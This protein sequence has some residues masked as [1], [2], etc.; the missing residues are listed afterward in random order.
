MVDLVTQDNQTGG[1]T[2]PISANADGQQ[3]SNDLSS[4]VQGAIG[5]DSPF[6]FDEEGMI[7]V[8]N[9]DGTVYTKI[10]PKKLPD[11]IR[12]K[13]SF[14][15]EQKKQAEM[16]KDL[17]LKQQSMQQQ[18]PAYN[19][20]PVKQDADYAVEG[21]A[22]AKR[23]NLNVDPNDVD[24]LRVLGIIAKSAEDNAM[25][26]VDAKLNSFTINQRISNAT[27]ELRQYNADIERDPLWLGCLE[28]A[29]RNGQ[30]PEDAKA[31]YLQRAG[32]IVPQQQAM[33]SGYGMP[34][35]N[36]QQNRQMN[37]TIPA[38]GGQRV[39]NVQSVNQQALNDFVMKSVESAQR[40]YKISDEATLK[41][42]AERAKVN[43]MNG[44]RG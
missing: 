27:N 5:S 25:A 2:S 3:L 29:C 40:D 17:L 21:A 23:F 16:F 31:L 34:L 14:A 9:P 35:M 38:M 8:S 15:S 33:N 13:D 7:V 12:E 36:P 28:M 43:F 11:V 6:N 24:G 37:T 18:Y 26:K 19:P 32:A 41:Q 1:Y 39:N 4:I 42:I 44:R 10:D 30:Q 22:L 20:V